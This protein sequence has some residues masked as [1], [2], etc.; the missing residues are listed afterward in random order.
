MTDAPQ[1]SAHHASHRSTYIQV[2]IWLVVLTAAELMLNYSLKGTALTIMLVAAAISKAA[3]VA[4]FF[5]HLKFDRKTLALLACA[6]LLIATILV[7]GL[8]PDAALWGLKG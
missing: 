7:I 2:F 1:V 8:M 5:M 3:L 4:M 6:P